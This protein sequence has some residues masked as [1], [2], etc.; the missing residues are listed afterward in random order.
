MDLGSSS[1]ENKVDRVKFAIAEK[2]GRKGERMGR[3]Q[4][5]EFKWAA[6]RWVTGDSVAKVAQVTGLI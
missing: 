5:H 4:R 2:K 3:E 1:S 6:I